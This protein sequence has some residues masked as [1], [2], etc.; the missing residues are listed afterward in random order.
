MNYS[1]IKK[2]TLTEILKT[3]TRNMSEKDIGKFYTKLGIV[4]PETLSYMITDCPELESVI[5]S[6]IADNKDVLVNAIA[7]N[8]KSL[9]QVYNILGKEIDGL[10]KDRKQFHK[11]AKIVLDDLSKTLNDS[12]LSPEERHNLISLEI[13]ILEIVA[14]NDSQIRD[15]KREARK[16]SIKKDSENNQFLFNCVMFG[17]I[18]FLLI[19][20][21]AKSV[22]PDVIKY[23]L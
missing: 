14:K 18:G 17:M 12:N 23:M 19:K 3:N 9:S 2:E 13:R 20:T 16:D 5:E 7:S 21:S 11:M 1:G 10:D 22:V 8:E 4:R 15:Q 6:V